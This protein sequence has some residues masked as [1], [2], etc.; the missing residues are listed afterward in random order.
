MLL[1]TDTR[2]HSLPNFV[3]TA[4]TGAGRGRRLPQP[5]P[6]VPLKRGIGEGLPAEFVPRRRG[7]GVVAAALCFECDLV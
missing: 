5:L 4:C 6:L 7:L 2:S 1:G 3:G